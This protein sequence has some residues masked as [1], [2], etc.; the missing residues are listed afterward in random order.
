MST[1]KTTITSKN[2]DVIVKT[3]ARMLLPSIIEFYNTK[4]GQQAF[5][6][7]ESQIHKGD[8]KIKKEE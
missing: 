8:E 5:E 7:W 3:L 4:E 1:R 6:K 2:D